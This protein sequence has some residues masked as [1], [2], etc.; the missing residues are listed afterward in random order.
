MLNTQN[1]YK[2]ILDVFY[3]IFHFGIFKDII[4]MSFVF[5]YL[6]DYHVPT[7]YLVNQNIRDKLAPV[8]LNRYGEDLLFYLFYMF[9]GDV[10]QVAA[11]AEL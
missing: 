8:K 1:I 6:L 7:E 5:S 4:F 2:K 9:S 3:Q 10:L 11:A